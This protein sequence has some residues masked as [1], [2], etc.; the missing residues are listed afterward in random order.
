MGPNLRRVF[1]FLAACGLAVSIG[2]YLTSFSASPA[3]AISRCWIVLLLGWMALVAPIYVI[4]YP[5]SRAASFAWTGF[6]RG[7]PSWVA[8][9]SWLLSLICGAHFAWFATH[10]GWGVPE[11]RD[12]Q[13][14]LVSHGRI[15]AVL[16]QAEYV[17]LRAAG[18]RMFAAGM[19]TVYF[20]PMTYWWFRRKASA[21]LPL[22]AK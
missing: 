4:E 7:M 8:P 11:I 9:C 12:G 6:A 3:D 22:P 14:A 2:S 19:I 5:A 21:P 13:Y 1:A 18:A 10:A 20:L 15:L 16:T 17:K